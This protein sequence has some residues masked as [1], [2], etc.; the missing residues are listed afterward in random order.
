MQDFKKAII[1]LEGNSSKIQKIRETERNIMQAL[2][3][4][5]IPGD[6][7]EWKESLKE[8]EQDLHQDDTL[9]IL[10]DSLPYHLCERPSV[11]LTRSSPW[12][13]SMARGNCIGKICHE[14]IATDYS[15]LM[16]I[17]A[18][19][20]EMKPTPMEAPLNYL[21]YS[22]YVP[23]SLDASGRN[24]LAK[25]SWT[26][27]RPKDI[28]FRILPYTCDG[29]PFVN[30]MLGEGLEAMQGDDDILIVVNSD[31]CVVPEATGI[32]RTFMDSRGIDECFGSRVDIQ[33]LAPLTFEQ[34]V[35]MPICAGMDWFA[36]RKTSKVAEVLKT[37]PLYLGREGWDCAWASE[38]RHRLPFNLCHHWPHPSDWQS[39]KGEEQNKFNRHQIEW[40][41]PGV[42]VVGVQ[43][44]YATFWTP[45]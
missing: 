35:G 21:I 30:Q 26:L 16:G 12:V 10:N 15:E 5:G 33:S 34:L 3:A 38:V 9:Y 29:L 18:R 6:F 24:G 44:K 43:E 40:N 14:V 32:I 31:I 2:Q 8:L 1:A 42:K 7:L 27:I 39:Q 28:H 4:L 17:I 19:N 11:L 22:E 20:R 23:G 41:F 45:Y 36:F 37:I 25:F 13:Q